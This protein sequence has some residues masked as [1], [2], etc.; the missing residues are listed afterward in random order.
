MEIIRLADRPDLLASLARGYEAEWPDWYG[1]GGPGDARADLTERSRTHGLPLG[2]VAAQDAVAIGAVALAER[3]IESHAHLSPWLI[4]L[5]VAPEWRGRG[6][7]ARLIR[8]AVHE[9]HRLGVRRLHAATATAASLFQREGWTLIDRG[10][11][12]RHA[13]CVFAIDL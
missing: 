5:W 10:E 4:G 6:A 9:A 3:S 1:P 12:A 11:D 2:I 8:A 7:G 13:A